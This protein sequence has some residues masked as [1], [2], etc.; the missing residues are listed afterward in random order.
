[1]GRRFGKAAVP[2]L[3]AVAQERP[4]SDSLQWLLEGAR[5]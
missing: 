1:V 2:V 3:E 5:S 4:E